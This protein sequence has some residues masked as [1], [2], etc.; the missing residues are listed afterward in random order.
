MYCQK[1]GG[2]IANGA[3]CCP[4]C[5]NPIQPPAEIKTYLAQSIIVTLCCCIPFGIVAIV[6]AARVSSLAA[7]G[8]IA[9]AQEASRKANMWSWIAFGVG[10]AA[11]A[12]YVI[13]QLLIP[14]IEEAMC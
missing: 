8:N 7:S 3:N 12:I 11:N 6:Y 13:I 9:A 2:E 1:C 5:Q 10:L 14:V 4:V